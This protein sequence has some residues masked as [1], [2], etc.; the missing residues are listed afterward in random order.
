[1]RACV[2][3]ASA[4][5][6]AVKAYRSCA[7]LAVLI[8]ALVTVGGCTR[9][10]SD[11]E[12]PEGYDFENP[13]G[14][15]PEV[16]FE[17]G[18]KPISLIPQP[19]N[20]LAKDDPTTR[21]GL[22]VNIPQE[23]ETQLGRDLRTRL[24]QLDGFANFSHVAV[25]FSMPI[26]LFTIR[27]EN[28][29]LVNVQRDS[30]YY[31]DIVELDLGKGYYP[32]NMV[33][34]EA[35]FPNDENADN[36]TVIFAADNRVDWYEDATNTL[37]IR[38]LVPLKQ[39]SKY[40][41]V[42]TTGLRGE[43][44][45]PVRP[46]DYF[47]KVTF[48]EQFDSLTDAAE[49]LAT[50]KGVS[51]KDIAFSWEFTTAT[52]TDHL[53]ELRRGLHG[54]GPFD[55]LADELV[56]KITQLHPFSMGTETDGNDYVMDARAFGSFMDLIGG[57]IEGGQNVPLDVMFGTDSVDY[58][59][60]GSF[61]TASFLENKD[62]VFHVN[63]D[64]GE[65]EWAPEEVP[66]YIAVPRP[67]AKNN[68]AQP[69]YPITFHQHAN[70]RNR[71]DMLALANH[72]AEQGI[73]TIGIDAAEHGPE[74]YVSAIYYALDSFND[75]NIGPI[76]DVPASLLVKI[77][78][79][80]FY[81]NIDISGLDS[82]ELVQVLKDKTFLGAML[83]G[84]T[85]DFD[86][87]G[88]IISGQSFYSADIFRTVAISH[89]TVFDL[90][91]AVRVLRAMGTDW[92]AN[93][94]LDLEEGDFNQDG[95]LDVAGPDQ[96]I[97][98]VGMSLGSLIGIPFVSL[99]PEIKSAV[100]N[101]P[102]GG[103]TDILQR[104]TIP[105]VNYGI[106]ADLTGPMIIGTPDK[107]KGVTHLNYH[108]EALDLEFGSE[109][110]NT[111][112]GDVP[113]AAGKRISMENTKTGVI[114]HKTVDATGNFAIAVGA[115]KGDWLRLTVT[116]PI[117]EKPI[118]KFEFATEY[119]GLGVDRN[120]PEARS[121]IDNAQWAVGLSDPISFAPHLAQDPLTEA[122][123]K[124]FIMQVCSPDSAIPL[125]AG[126][127]IIRA[128]GIIDDW[129]MDN[130]LDRG[131]LNEIRVSFANGNLPLQSVAHQAWRVHPGYN[132]EY[133]LAP[134][135]DPYSIMYSIAARR[136]AALFLKSHGE[137]IEDNLYMLVD[138]EW[139]ADPLDPDVLEE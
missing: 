80:I 133:M 19:N 15:G 20:I 27:D 136:Q 57:F 26:N 138:P 65:A 109:V 74:T 63:Y 112:I 110:F 91:Q 21:T 58:I 111:F 39:S 127:A 61:T 43:N 119:R 69:P 22:R 82:K 116:D 81:P 18:A 98:F 121:F 114:K 60:S 2:G 40:A 108:A 41:V 86:G 135:F 66:F 6:T 107:A 45:F 51:P 126:T 88:L 78:M 33:D 37:L 100:F 48:P 34:P 118:G 11:D 96:E 14:D 103:L 52:I 85:P 106:R 139:L 5:G 94:K 129:H 24:R 31:G 132:H 17:P 104:T 134:R 95:V 42:L 70:I 90:F 16:L 92:N 59:V 76:G 36:P 117:T 83:H 46:P 123:P 4:W 25:S 62:R 137:I 84:R 35:F 113:L 54:E 68:Y 105:N 79:A 12:R 50:K 101:V 1:M 7:W 77:I 55:Y 67:C 49:I 72:M 102:G 44:G 125:Q 28:I 130:L 122:G 97:S 53:Q 128:A 13:G 9:G 120:T 3:R 73:A 89:Q 56:P 99:E 23:A 10:E 64:T 124:N 71:L 115:D 93:G 8:L 38:P 30:K 131:A 75:L 29:Y 32:K 87:D 47:E